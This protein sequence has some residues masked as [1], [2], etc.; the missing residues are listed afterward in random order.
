MRRGISVI[1]FGNERIHLNNEQNSNFG[2]KVSNYPPCPKPDLIKGLRAHTDAGG[3]IL[4]FQDDKVGGLQL[5][6]DGQ[7]IDVPPMRHSIVINLGD[8]IEV[9][10]NGKYKSVLHRVIAQTDGKRM[11]IASFYNPGNDAVISPAPALVKEL[12]VTNQVYPK[13]VFDDYMKLYAGLN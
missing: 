3:I 4:L 8:Q 6:K 9:I 12:D 5:L 11:S 7:W 2:T 13:F 1:C 10:T